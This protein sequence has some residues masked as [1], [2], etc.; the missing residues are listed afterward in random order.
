MKKRVNAMHMVKTCNECDFKTK[1]RI[2]IKRHKDTQHQPD[3]YYEQ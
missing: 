3:D 1:S 2:E